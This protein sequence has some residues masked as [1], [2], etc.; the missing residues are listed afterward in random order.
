MVEVQRV[1]L[2]P[3][4]VPATVARLEVSRLPGGQAM[5]RR[6]FIA[7]AL[8]A[9][10]VGKLEG[11]R[12]PSVPTLPCC[13]C[14]VAC[15]SPMRWVVFVRAYCADCTPFTSYGGSMPTF[16]TKPHHHESLLWPDPFDL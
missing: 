11:E 14:G 2:E 15:A 4:R 10:V 16:V 6:Q 5:N 8:A 1:R 9:P 3:A 13:K 12:A 7:G